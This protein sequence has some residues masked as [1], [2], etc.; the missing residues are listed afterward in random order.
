MPFE[1][2]QA[3]V[4]FFF[5]FFVCFNFLLFLL[6][7]RIDMCE[8]EDDTAN[9]VRFFFVDYFLIGMQCVKDELN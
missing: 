5:F 6:A 4:A 9:V 1:G 7:V 8:S 2:Q 3:L